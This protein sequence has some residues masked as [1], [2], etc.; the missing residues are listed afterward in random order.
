MRA[1]SRL[2]PVYPQW[3]DP[4]SRE[5]PT[6]ILLT[7]NYYIMKI[8]QQLKTT[9]SLA[10]AIALTTGATQ[11]GVWASSPWSNDTDLTN[12]LSSSA[13]YT[14]AVDL[15]GGTEGN[16]SAVTIASTGF[17]QYEF[18]NWSN[19]ARNGTGWSYTQTDQ[20]YGGSAGS[21]PSGTESDKLSTGFLGAAAGQTETLSL[22]GLSAN[23]DY[24]FTLFN[25]KWDNNSRTASLDGLDDGAGN[26][27]VTDPDNTF[28]SYAYNT[29]AGTTFS[30]DITG[31]GSFEYATYA[32]TN[33]VVPEPSTTA[34]LGLG[35]LA[36]IL[37]RRK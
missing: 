6:E 12:Y 13:T 19:V 25:A 29:G 14:H 35:G 36:L 28:V 2:I 10:T 9:M 7:T 32:F 23:T 30:M 1:K 3:I 17:T 18:T 26:A 16:E 31:T 24:V 4:V 27:R 8:N 37:R 33:A 11:A 21:G 34:L 20:A 15:A 5:E 22:S